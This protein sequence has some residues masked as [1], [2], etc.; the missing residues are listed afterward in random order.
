MKNKKTLF[1][2]ILLFSLSIYLHFLHLSFPTK[3]VFDEQWYASSSAS[4]FSQKYYFDTHPPLV[5]LLIAGS[6]YVFG[7]EEPT[8]DFYFKHGDNYP[9]VKN[10]LP[11]RFLPA[12]L[13][14]LLPILGWF[15]V[16][17]LG[18]SKKAAFLAGIFLLFDNALLLQSRL[19]LIE[20]ILVFF[21]LL[22]VLFYLLFRKQ[23]K[24][25]RKWYFFLLLLGVSL[26][27]TIS[28]KWSG[29]IS[30]VV[31]LFLEV[32]RLDN[33]QVEKKQKTK[34]FLKQKKKEI[35]FIFI[36]IFVIPFIVYVFSF[37]LHF[38]LLSFQRDF[39]NVA[40]PLSY[41]DEET[42]ADTPYVFHLKE[43]PGNFVN[44]FIQTHKIMIS[45]FSVDG[46][47]PYSSEWWGWPI[48]RK[49]MLYF[50]EG[51]INLYLLGNP[52][53]WFFAFFAVL[54]LFFIPL[55]KAKNK[56]K[57]PDFFRNRVILYFYFFSLLVYVGFSSTSFLF[58]YFLPLCFSI[59]IFSLCFDFYTQKMSEKKKNIIWALLILIC[60]LSFLFYLPFTYGIPLSER[61]IS[62]RLWLPFWR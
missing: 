35:G 46:E 16:R 55:Y 52:V 38:S 36:A 60:F 29:I 32:L 48:G 22:S 23:K 19:I 47:H 34:N 28:V 49:A 9:N 43:P 37:F 27:A 18:G 45:V 39:N 2:L 24:Y 54:S 14:S 53:V 6:G 30:L 5:K 11:F 12:I 56:L 8:G 7:F 41:N 15:I 17:E 62:L 50:K 59:I 40:D 4:Y 57:S 33:E 3:V 20:I 58:Y 21:S 1:F 51:D 13:G 25:K 31:I 44:K 26:G 61:A 10:Y 42:T